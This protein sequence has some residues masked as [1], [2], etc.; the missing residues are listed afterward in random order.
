MSRRFKLDE[1]RRRSLEER[2]N[3]GEFCVDSQILDRKEG[4][5]KTIPVC[6]AAQAEVVARARA[7]DYLLSVVEL[8]TNHRWENRLPVERTARRPNDFSPRLQRAF[9]RHEFVPRRELM[10]TR[11]GM[12]R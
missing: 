3:E 8:T 6:S 5:R 11:R 9:Q 12:P 4:E 1:N 7:C 10:E 2:A